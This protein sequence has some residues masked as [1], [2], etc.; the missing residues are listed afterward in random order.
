MSDNE[1]RIKP[2]Y[3]APIVVALGGLAQG[4]GYCAAGSSADPGYC[5]A[6]A[7][8]ATACTDGG[9]ALT[10]ACTTGTAPGA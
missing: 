7:A 8:A 3:E 6:G 4:T 9:V 1:K 2:K 5:T 10:A